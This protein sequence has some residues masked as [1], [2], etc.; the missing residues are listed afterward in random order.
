LKKDWVFVSAEQ[1]FMATFDNLGVRLSGYRRRI[2]H[3]YGMWVYRRS[4][5]LK[6][7]RYEK[8][9]QDVRSRRPRVFLGPDLPYGGVRGHV[10]NIAKYSALDVQLVPDERALG[11]LENF[12]GEAHKRFMDFM[13]DGAPVVH[14]HVVPWMIRWCAEQQRNG[15]RWVHTYHLPYFPEHGTTGLKPDQIEINEALIHE[16]CHADVRLSVSRWQQAYLRSE[17]GIETDYLPNGVD[18]TACDAGSE[19]SFRRIFN[20]LEPFILYVGRN[21]PVKNPAEFIQLASAL[22]THQFVVIGQGLGPGVMRRDWDLETPSNVRY[23]GGATHGDVQDALAACAAL[24]VTSKREGLPT[25]VLEAMAHGKP[26]VVADEAGCL[27]AISDGKFGFI[28]HLGDL[29]SLIT[30]TLDALQDG[31]RCNHARQRV[32]EE[33]DWR[34]VAPRLDA[35]YLN[36]P[37]SQP[38]G[39]KSC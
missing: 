9:I 34:V 23:L 15:S 24:V 3:E 37:S 26:I 38:V 2:A 20:I 25:L 31:K 21:D 18:V 39:P 33:Y 5:L 6:L 22:P 11:G 14:S 27:E 36:S 30:Q 29:D 35:I 4:S 13:P 10:R 19:K 17:H 8:W 1:V 16:A 7:R 12:S 28:Y 32:L